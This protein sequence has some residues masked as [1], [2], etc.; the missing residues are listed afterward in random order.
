MSSSSSSSSSPPQAIPMNKV[1]N[2]QSYHTQPSTTEKENTQQPRHSLSDE[3]ITNEPK[4]GEQ[5]IPIKQE[6]HQQMQQKPEPRRS[7]ASDSS[8]SHSQSHSHS[9]SSSA[10]RTSEDTD[11]SDL[12]LYSGYDREGNE[13]TEFCIELFTCFGV[14]DCYPKSGAGC[15]TTTAT[16]VGNLVFGCCKC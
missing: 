9:S 2:A 5:M 12:S 1:N 4:R 16:F 13:C 3:T 7:N 10:S 8:H 15:L 11:E 14:V 6:Q